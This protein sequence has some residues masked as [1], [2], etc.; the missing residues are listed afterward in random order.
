MSEETKTRKS[1]PIE[2]R[3][4]DKFLAEQR[5]ACEELAKLKYQKDKLEAKENALKD[6]L[7]TKGLLDLKERVE[8]E[9]GVVHECRKYII[10]YVYQE[11]IVDIDPEKTWEKLNGVRKAFMEV[12]K[13]SSGELQ[14]KLGK[15][16]VKKLGRVIE[17]KYIRVTNGK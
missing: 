5:S 16:V 14:K 2:E 7:I 15:D 10:E 1:I 17:K 4:N 8:V 13:V 9:L 11:E 12:V 3:L 6:E